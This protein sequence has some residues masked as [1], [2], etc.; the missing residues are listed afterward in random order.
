MPDDPIEQE[1]D[2][3]DTTVTTSSTELIQTT[4]IVEVSEAQEGTAA[5]KLMRTLRA[6]SKPDEDAG[7]LMLMLATVAMGLERNLGPELERTQATGEL[8]E[9]LGGLTRWIATHRSQT[10]HRLVVV[11]LP[12]CQLSE[13]ARL[14]RLRTAE[15]HAETARSPLFS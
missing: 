2:T 14:H 7:E 13:G 9:F 4:E 3:T 11:E 5:A 6:L 10:A 1:Q 12:R 15:A 8:D